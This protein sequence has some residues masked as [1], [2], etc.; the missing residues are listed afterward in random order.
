MQRISPMTNY[1]SS[2]PAVCCLITISY[3][4]LADITIL[5]EPTGAN[6]RSGS[7]ARFSIDATSSATNVYYQW[8]LNGVPIPDAD[9]GTYVTSVLSTNDTG[10][11]YFVQVGDVSGQTNLNPPA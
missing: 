5:K 6:S 8:F 4:A 11:V 7:R 1:K 3:T 9:K 2:L 10:N